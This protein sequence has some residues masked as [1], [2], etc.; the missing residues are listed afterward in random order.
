MALEVGWLLPC[1][2][3]A[4]AGTSPPTIFGRGS[5]GSHSQKED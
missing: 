5:L 1:Y 4:A 2:L 3:E